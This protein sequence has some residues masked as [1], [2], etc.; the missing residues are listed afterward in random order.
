MTLA[1]DNGSQF[2]KLSDQIERENGIRMEY[3]VPYT[4]EQ[5]EVA[6]RLNS[7]IFTMVRAMLYEAGLPDAFWGIAAESVV[8]I[9]NRVP[10][11]KEEK[12]PEQL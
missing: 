7:M 6:E 9:W 3:T 1:A 2:H 10:Q 8:Y 5:K 4:P 12:T 11:G